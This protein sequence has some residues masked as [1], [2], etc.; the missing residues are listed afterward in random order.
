MMA[1]RSNTAWSVAFV[2]CVCVCVCCTSNVLLFADAAHVSPSRHLGSV[3]SSRP[4]RASS[5]GSSAPA[6]ANGHFV[7]SYW[8]D[9][10]IY[11]S[12]PVPTQPYPLP[13]SINADGSVAANADLTAK[14]EHMNA[15][16]YAFLQVG[17]DGTTYFN[18]PNADLRVAQSFANY[19][20]LFGASGLCTVDSAIC[21]TAQTPAA[22]G[23]GNFQA[24]MGLQN[25]KGTLKKLISV[26]GYAHDAS[27]LSAFR[28]PDR[29]AST[30]KLILD[31][32]AM[33]GID[34][35]FEPVSMTP[36]L[37]SQYAALVAKVRSA[38]GS[39]YIISLAVLSGPSWLQTVG[40][41]NWKILSANADFID[42]M[43]YDF[44]GG[45]DASGPVG[46][47]GYLTSLTADAAS[48]YNPDFSVQQSV[49]SLLGMGVPSQ[50]I[51]VGVPAYGRMLTGVAAGSNF[52]LF[53]KFA[54]VAQGNQDEPSCSTD[55]RSGIACSGS[56]TYAYLAQLVA[57]GTFVQHEWYD[58]GVVSGVWAY[59]DGQWTPAGTQASY[60]QAF[61][62]Y[63]DASLVQSYVS[64]VQ[65]QS[66]GGMLMWDVHG[67]VTPGTSGSQS[68]LLQVMSQL[69]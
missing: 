51:V 8:T 42:L 9:W 34:L 3:H 2:V 56:F 37:A 36:D 63:A 19:D 13:G 60:S 67:D 33:D 20:A 7:M 44:H 45:F 27:F 29:F 65:S 4:A 49:Q 30:V 69:C 50:K 32:T 10:S 6:A 62:S 5:A 46:A 35:D 22:W 11:A 61:V 25:S 24:F 17:Q 52:G 41:D 23:R 64:Y 66:L 48:P 47:T 31:K 55:P 39:R 12:T 38:I 1:A 26:G 59:H 14:L 57:A 28:N 21:S 16:A 40:A 53:E 43:T 15:L 54:G 18:D 68:S 58:G